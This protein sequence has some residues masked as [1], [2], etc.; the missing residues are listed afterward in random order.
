MNT[1]KVL[2]WLVPVAVLALL[3]LVLIPRL[4]GPEQVPTPT[5]W[6]TEGWRSSTPEEQGFDSARLAEELQ[7]IRQ[8]GTQVH[9]IL[10]IRNGSVFLD[11]YFYPYDGSTY[12]D[13]ASV[14]KSLITTLIGI[15]ADQGKLGLDDTMVSFF[16]ERTIAKRSELKDRI[17]V[18]HLASMTSGLDCNPTD[19]AITTNEMRAS[20]DWVQFA[21]DREA[22]QKP[23]THFKYCDLEMHLL[24]AILQEATGMTALEFARENLFE[25]L[26]IVDVYWPADPQGYTHGWGDAC[27]H[28]GDMAK[29]GFLFLHQGQRDGRQI[30]SQEWVTEATKAQAKTG[31]DRSEDYGFGWWIAR[32]DETFPFFSADGRDGQFIRVF[33]DLDLIVVTTGGGFNDFAQVGDYLG[34]AIGDLEQPLPANP[35]G[36]ADLRT[37]LA[38]LRQ[39]PPAQQVPLLPEIAQTISGRTYVFEPNP[40]QLQF[41]R[42]D[43]DGSAEAVMQLSIAYEPSPRV[44][45]IGLDGVY[46]SS[47]SG[48]PWVARGTWIDETTFQVEYDEGPGL[49]A[50][51]MRMHF[52]GDRMLFEVPGLVSIEGEQQQP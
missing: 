43:F 30:V 22:V 13:V 16:P 33:P 25:P 11:A 28:P 42:I 36:E 26:G 29:L 15:A 40:V 4:R 38:S 7:A 3:A 12:H 32:K 52:D 8:N 39:T 41:L 24:S 48:R 17:T 23:G 49:A 51:T 14:T 9:S 37:M 19:Y 2:V 27:L 5:Y 35:A 10:G 47:Q 45:G 46:R 31:S 34:A 44:G 20:E 18:R 21:L 6:P 1:R 50:Y